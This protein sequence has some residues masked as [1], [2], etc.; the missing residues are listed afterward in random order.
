MTARSRRHLRLRA[1]PLMALA[2]WWLSAA[3][4]YACSVCY[5][6]AANPSPLITSARLGVFLLLAITA[7]VLGG[8]ARFFLILSRR[9]RQAEADTIAAEWAQLQRSSP[10]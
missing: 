6:S 3:P 2:A 4:A 5:G 9:A 8:F 1:L 10:L 7:A